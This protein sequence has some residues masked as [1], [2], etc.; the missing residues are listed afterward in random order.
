MLLTR[1]FT[2]THLFDGHLMAPGSHR[3][4][5]WSQGRCR[6]GGLATA[7]APPLRRVRSGVAAGQLQVVPFRVNDDG[8][9]VLPVWLA[10]KPMLVD[11]PGASVPL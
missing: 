1:A 8:A 6:D 3:P 5:R 9:A 7:P 10:W 11:A 4:A 2:E